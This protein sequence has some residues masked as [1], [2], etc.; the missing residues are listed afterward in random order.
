MANF[1]TW[2][3]AVNQNKLESTVEQYREKIQMMMRFFQKNTYA[4]LLCH[5]FYMDL[6]DLSI[7]FNDKDYSSMLF[8]KIEQSFKDFE[9]NRPKLEKLGASFVE[10]AQ[11][12]SEK[13]IV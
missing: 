4:Q 6:L 13:K 10:L 12:L 9:E 5:G 1:I 2:E 8:D 3:Q 11:Q 7:Y